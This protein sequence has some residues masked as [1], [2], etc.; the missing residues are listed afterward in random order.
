ML[1]RILGTRFGIIAVQL[2]EEG[3]FGFMVS[4]KNHS[5]C[6]VPISDAVHKMRRVDPGGQLVEHARAVEISFG[7]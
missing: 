7:D 5:T 1:D 2:L 4:Y 3:K 6:A